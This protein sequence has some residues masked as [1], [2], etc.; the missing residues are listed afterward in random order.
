M[1]H[2]HYVSV[3]D[4]HGPIHSKVQRNDTGKRLASAKAVRTSCVVFHSITTL[5]AVNMA[6]CFAAANNIYMM[7]SIR[8]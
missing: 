8:L 6:C 7:Q 4:K 2:R 1:P 5:E 3:V